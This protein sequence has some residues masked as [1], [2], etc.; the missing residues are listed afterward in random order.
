MYTICNSLDRLLPFWSGQT[1]KYFSKP[2]SFCKVLAEFMRKVAIY[3][4]HKHTI[5]HRRPAVPSFD[6]LFLNTV[7]NRKIGENVGIITYQ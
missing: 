5:T 1:F 3:L 4:P 6:N 7:N 2:W